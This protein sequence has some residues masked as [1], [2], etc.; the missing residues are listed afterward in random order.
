MGLE[1][2]TI[3]LIGMALSAAGAGATAYDAKRTAD[4]QDSAAAQGI[5]NQAAKQREMDERVNTE[6]G[7]LEGSNPDDE[8][9]AS[10]EKFM[11]T[12]RSARGNMEGNLGAAPAGSRY[13]Q[14]VDQSKAA[15]GNFGEK[16]AGILSRIRAAGDQRQN[17]GFAINR[18]GSD[19]AG[20][21]R[22]ASGQ[23]FLDRLRLGGITGNPWTQAAGQI[24]KGAGSGMV[25]YAGSMDPMRGLGD[26]PITTSRIPVGAAAGGNVRNAFRSLG[27]GG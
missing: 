17:E 1:A 14:D 3:A 13:G 2:G 20:T 11:Q 5:R 9:A 18:M 19:V 10:L 15:I 7:A 25:G 26:I 8:R 4:A 16:A 27:P 12:L 23:D 24:A 21:A 22:E 6:I